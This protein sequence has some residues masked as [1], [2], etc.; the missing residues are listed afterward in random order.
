MEREM[1]I[2]NTD[3]EF[4]D[5]ASVTAAGEAIWPVMKAAGAINFTAFQTSETTG[6]T[7][8]VWPD[9]A[10]AQAAID[11]VRAKAMELADMKMVGSAAG[12]AM[13]QLS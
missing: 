5:V 9:G 7:I 13:L 11:D 1:F 2:T 8:V 12:N 4:A 10:T 6:R 3:W